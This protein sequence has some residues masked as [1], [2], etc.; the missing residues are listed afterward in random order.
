MS[1]SSDR[2]GVAAV[3][4]AAGRST[5]MGSAKPLLPFGGRTVVEHVVATL[6]AAGLGPIHVVVGHGGDA[7]A[8][9]LAGTR[10]VVV[11]N[12]D[13][14]RGMYSSLRAGVA[15]LPEAIE[16]TLLL[17][18][19]VP[20]VRATTFAR[21]ADT[22]IA[23]GRAVLPTFR[24]ERGHPPF[25][26]KAVFA[27]ILTGDGEGGLRALLARRAGEAREVAVFDRACLLD[28]DHP[29]DYARLAE[30]LPHRGAPEPEECEAI[31][32]GHAVA[33]PV[34]RHCRAVAGLAVDLAERLAAAGVALDLDLVRA[35]ALLHDVAKGHAHH[36]E[37][38]AAMLR[39]LGF[40]AVADVVARHMRIDFGEGD[41]IDEAAVVHLADKCVAEERRVTLAERFVAAEAKFR[42]DPIALAG[43]RR[44]RATAETILRE[45]EARIA[46][47]ESAP[48][49]GAPRIA[50]LP[51]ERIAR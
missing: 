21:I 4:L 39:D 42:D 3:V 14:D 46:F 11:D 22:G 15:S 33:D 40:P 24:G 1:G 48:V 2:S 45:V 12:P 23:C 9:A 31:L 32:E 10:A 44:R 43:A 29:A 20:A 7:I 16:G 17:P 35:G 26:P 51:D 8:R 27:E 13:H 36:A 6:D 38:G 34:R 5:R 25:L 37:I 18:C 47:P 30:A 19:D 50:S 28:I 41:R 49:G